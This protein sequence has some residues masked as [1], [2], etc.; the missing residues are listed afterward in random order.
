MHVYVIDVVFMLPDGTERRSL[1]NHCDHGGNSIDG[2]INLSYYSGDTSETI[3]FK[4]TQEQLSQF[5]E[6]NVEIDVQHRPVY[7]CSVG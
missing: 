4:M 6:I 7:D 3:T 2:L 5:T 1:F